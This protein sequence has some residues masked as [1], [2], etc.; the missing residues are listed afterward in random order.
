MR[1]TLA[2]L[3]NLMSPRR[4]ERDMAHEIDAHLR[5][6]QDEFELQ[7]MSPEDARR[8][9]KRAYGGV[10]QSKELHREA[11]SFI[12]IEQLFKDIRYGARNLRRSP[13]FTL[14]AVAALALG[15]GAN[16]AVFSIVN[17]VLLTPLSVPD[18]DRFVVLM[19]TS[20]DGD[21][22]VASPANFIHWRAQTSAL[23]DVSAMRTGAMNYTGGEVIE[24]WQS[25]QVSEGAF[26]AFG[27]PLIQGRGFTLEEDLPSG[28]QVAVISANLWKRRFASDPLI[29]G[30]KILLSGNPYT[31]VGVADDSANLVNEMGSNQAP[32]LDV[33]VPFQI[34]PNTR[35]Q[36]HTFFVV[37][38][39][40][41]GITLQ[42]AQ[43][44]L[45]ASTSEYRAKS[46]GT[47]GP[48]ASFTVKPVLEIVLADIRSL[49]LVLTGAVGLVLLIACANVANLLLVRA[50]SRRHEIGI[51]MA[52]GA[53]R[54]RVIRQLLA[55][56]VL[57]ALSGGAV[58]LLIGYSGIRAL[59]A[60]VNADNLP[61]A[62]DIGMDWHMLGFALAVSLLTG[63]VF[64]L[65]PAL[66]STRADLNT[67]LKD[68]GRWG[69]GLRQ[70]KAKASLVISEVSLAMVLLVGSALLIRTF[71]A[72]YKVDRGFRTN[73]VITMQ[74]S[75]TGPKYTKSAD[76]A[77]ATTET[78]ERIRSL[79]GVVAA[80]ATCCV[81]LQIELNSTF[82]IVGR[83]AGDNPKTAT[84]A[85]AT[86]S[87]GYFD[88][89]QIP[90]KRGRVFTDRDD[91][92]SPGVVVINE[93]MAKEYWK[94]I[95]P[96]NDRLLIGHGP[97]ENS[98][99]D[100]PRQIIGIVADVHQGAL[101]A[102]PRPMMYVPQ[103]QLPNSTTA[104]LAPIVPM[105]WIV[106]TQKNTE[107]LVGAIQQQVRRSTGLPVFNVQSM[108]DV[109]RLSTGQQQ[110][111]ALVMTIFGGSA[112]L[113]AAIG[114]Y[115]LMAYTVE[116]RTQ[117]IG[118]RLALGAEATQLR[119]MVVRQG[120]SLA[121]TGVGIGLAAAWGAS[122]WMESILFGV[123]PRDPI[124]FIAVP[125]ALGAV[126][127]LSVWLPAK[128]ALRVD[129][130]VAL[131]HN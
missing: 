60:S 3:A 121:M 27:L 113:L 119:N 93:R 15:I 111:N 47:L 71:V 40:K 65:L 124:V 37:A 48:N 109:V 88:V 17:S 126:A 19:N 82:D 99:D 115:G 101:D 13:G 73:N 86:A 31:V 110:F 38:R 36:D 123:K 25:A 21:S 106:R 80:S 62:S 43:E 44:R 85:W 11:R 96:L 16:T 102:A 57:L 2:K 87:A 125:L 114:I 91:A 98:G 81:P 32:R 130:A 61:P 22:P 69:S 53:G 112:L 79:P 84:G 42:Q 108:D 34:D 92:T 55:E 95:D 54:A 66:E 118:I 63:I 107:A 129:P 41:P 128:R 4:A 103:A 117:E 77:N 1:R 89:F 122:R 9:A 52:V 39:L 76:L 78:L 100:L 12:W 45:R 26:R 105:S 83:P 46:P 10:E 116:Q 59:L 29:L 8:A 64:G 120:M 49:L 33:Y 50:A 28:P 30:K 67:V 72:L 127:L 97:G 35:D 24:Q 14:T 104:K 20:E 94:N 90:L 68:G 58:G 7:G 75:F 5:L 18:P 56:S 51:R 70:N 74:T 131:R 23:Q 6:L